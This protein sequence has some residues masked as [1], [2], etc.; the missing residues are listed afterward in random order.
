M[1]NK[2]R[3]VCAPLPGCK[4]CIEYEPLTGY[5][6]RRQEITSGLRWCTGYKSKTQETATERGL[7]TTSIIREWLIATAFNSTGDPEF[8]ASCLI[9]ADKLAELKEFAKAYQGLSGK[10]IVIG[11]GARSES[12]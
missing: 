4:G 9:I 3:E 2:L 7:L 5:C 1:P 12:V 10:E 11:K 6:N 8:C